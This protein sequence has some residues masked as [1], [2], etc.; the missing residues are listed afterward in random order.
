MVHGDI[1]GADILDDST[2]QAQRTSYDAAESI[3]VGPGG[4]DWQNTN[5]NPWSHKL[6]RSRLPLYDTRHINA[7]AWDAFAKFCLF[8]FRNT[9]REARF[10]YAFM[11][12]MHPVSRC[13]DPLLT[14]L[15]RLE[16]DERAMQA[17][18]R[19]PNGLFSRKMLI[20]AQ[21][22]YNNGCMTDVRWTIDFSHRIGLERGKLDAGDV[23]EPNVG[24]NHAKDAQLPEQRSLKISQ[25]T[26]RVN[27]Y[28][29]PSGG[30]PK[31]CASDLSRSRSSVGNL[32]SNYTHTAVTNIV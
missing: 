28:Q 24:R 17:L 30:L 27:S 31:M 6:D 22:C 7:Q 14:W 1:G 18:V 4:A 13:A 32:H 19:M 15:C 11:Q 21:Y 9:L 29:S 8:F 25:L 23:L 10:Q 16:S 3:E 20:L 5:P 26:L 12:S 2:E